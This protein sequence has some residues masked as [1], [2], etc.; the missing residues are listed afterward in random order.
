MLRLAVLP[1]A[2]LLIVPACVGADRDPLDAEDAP[3]PSGKADGSLEAGSPEARA[4]LALVNDSAVDVGVLDDGAALNR[5]A[6]EHIIAHRDG[7]DGLAGTSDDDLFDD[8]GELDDVRYVGPY[9]LGQLLA[10]A[11]ANGYGQ[12]AQAASVIFSPMPYENS[13]NVRVAGLIDQAQH[14]LDIAMYSYSDARI[15][16]ALERAVARGVNVRFI[17]ETARQDRTLTGT[18]L[19]SSKSGRLEQIGI[20]VRWVN[21]IMHHKFVIIDGPRDEAARA[22]TATIVSGSGNWSNG[23]ATRY[24]ENTLFLTGHREQTLRLQQEF[25][26]MWAHSR[27]VVVDA[28]LPYE[29]SSYDIGA[30]G[31]LDEPDNHAY[32]T[33]DNFTVSGTTFRVSGKNTVSDALVA[34]IESADTSIHVATGHLR[35]RPISEALLAAKIARP[36]LDIKIYLDGQEFISDWYQDEQ[37]GELTACLAAAT[38]ESQTRSCLDKGY[39]FSHEVAHSDIDLRFKYYAYRWHFSYA[40]QMHHKYLVI[41]GDEVWTGSYN[42]SDNAEHNTFENVMVFE[43]P[44]FAGLAAAYAANFA[45][46]WD[47]GRDAGQYASLM[48]EVATAS[49]IPL[50]FDSMALTFDEVATLKSAIYANCPEINSDAF[51]S[52]PERHWTCPR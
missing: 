42:Q 11:L 28:S 49:T 20:N 50:V 25:N 22:D 8:L 27:D 35:S 15:A 41:D 43:G 37:A 45:A 3:F 24:D 14:T 13:H 2:V 46:M 32:F 16:A 44:R 33:S 34:A 31:I 18:A 30:A 1:L 47:T 36:W 40:V 19:T 23:A 21:K 38:S 29:L 6:A 17:F 26:L 9:A 52:E 39:Y 5:L 10:Y 4:V 12:P 7:A 51:R 48:D